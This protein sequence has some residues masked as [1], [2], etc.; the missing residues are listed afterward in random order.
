VSDT[1]IRNILISPTKST[2]ETAI[3]D[4]NNLYFISTTPQTVRPGQSRPALNDRFLSYLTRLICAVLRPVLVVPY[5]VT[6]YRKRPEN[7]VS[8][9]LRSF[10]TR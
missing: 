1:N 5:T 8:D 4:L 7:R 6:N 9:R 2:A 3:A 10:T